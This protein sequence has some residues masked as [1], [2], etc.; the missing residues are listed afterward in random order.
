MAWTTPK[1]DWVSTDRF[2]I[3]DY[4]RIKNNLDYLYEVAITLCIPFEISDMGDD[5]TNY[6]AYW[7]ADEFNLFEQNLE[8]INNSV[9]VQEIGDTAFFEPN[10]L[11]IDYE[12]LNR[13]EAATLAIYDLFM[14]RIK[15]GLTRLSFRLGTFKEVRI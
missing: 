15:P 2:N 9:Y 10:G 1:T 12:E 6:E 8:T 14:N 13:I 11:F 4:N 3:E 5:I 7:T